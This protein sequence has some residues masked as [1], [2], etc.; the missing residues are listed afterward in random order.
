MADTYYD[1]L[2]LSRKPSKDDLLLGYMQLA[3]KWHPENHGN[4]AE[5]V[6]KFRL[7][8]EAFCVLYDTKARFG[9]DKSLAT[10]PEG[11]K[12]RRLG[13]TLEKTLAVFAEMTTRYVESD[14]QRGL[15]EPECVAALTSAGCPLE[16]AQCLA[17]KIFAEERS[18]VQKSGYI[19][20]GTGAAFFSLGAGILLFSFSAS[21]GKSYVIWYWPLGVGLALM[22]YAFYC[23]GTGRRALSVSALFAGENDN[24]PFKSKRRR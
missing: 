14:M 16:V 12:A 7:V 9:Y 15:T 13:M 2:G 24:R 10:N 23:I 8:G 21:G 17:G 4:S 6:E 19:M 3:C 22:L 1:V 11:E 5:A 18:E 20:L